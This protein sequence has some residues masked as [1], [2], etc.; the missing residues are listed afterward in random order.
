ME[1]I[2]FKIEDN[3]GYISLSKPP[4]NEMNNSFFKELSAVLETIE[5]DSSL[6][7]VIISSEGRHFSSG[8]DVSELLSYFPNT[9]VEFPKEL[10]RNNLAFQK[11]SSLNIPVLTCLKGICY[12]SALEL[13]L[14]SHFRIAESSTRMSLPETS[15]GITPG[16]GGIYNSSKLMGK[17][18]AL[19][20]ILS[21]QSFSGKEA[22]NEGLVDILAEKNKSEQVALDL[23]KKIGSNY[24]RELRSL[25]LS[26]FDD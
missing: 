24:K 13:A 2:K 17:S 26:K 16:L 4:K 18:K 22:L 19:Q 15:F 3:V 1:K 12:S 10:E 23:I 9:I 25:Y 21:E 5:A 14:A 20:F 6:I 11:I 8:A 7:A